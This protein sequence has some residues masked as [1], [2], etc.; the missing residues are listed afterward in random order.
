MMTMMS[1]SRAPSPHWSEGLNAWVDSLSNHALWLIASDFDGTLSPLVA[2]AEDAALLPGAFSILERLSRNSR[3]LLAFISGR[4]LKDLAPRLGTLAGDAL[5]AGNHGLEIAGKGLDWV[6]PEAVAVR[7][8]LEQ[9]IGR[10][11]QLLPD[12]PD[13]RIEDKGLSLTV[14]YRQLEDDL[15][16]KLAER[17][18][19]LE[20]PDGIG[21][22]E[23]KKV[24]EFRP[25]ISWN[26]GAAIRE[27]LGRFHIADAATIFLGD[28]TTDEDVFTRID[29]HSFTVH[30]GSAINQ[31]RAR[32]YARD[33][34]DAVN[35][36]AALEEKARQRG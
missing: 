10:L 22:H 28:D 8:V 30:V 5:M 9:L 15:I 13:A 16:P 6:H 31:S 34:E 25:E 35:C 12:L 17:M 1:E 3:V 21:M 33:P 20:L 19:N 7:P 2:R 36:L 11:R 18:R 23:G 29:A 4:G 24:F 32:F 26:K 27:V 14:H